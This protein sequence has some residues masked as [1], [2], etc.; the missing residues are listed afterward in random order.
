[1]PQHI[2]LKVKSASPYVKGDTAGSTLK[3]CVLE[4]GVEVQTPPYVQTGQMVVVNTADGSF[5]RR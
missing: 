3:P 4:N 5:V 1:M 2:T